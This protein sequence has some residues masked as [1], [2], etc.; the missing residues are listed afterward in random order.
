MR[1]AAR[2]QICSWD[3]QL[4]GSFL[5]NVHNLC[6]TLIR[7]TCFVTRYTC[8]G[9]FYINMGNLRGSF[10]SEVRR[11]DG[12]HPFPI[13]SLPLPIALLSDVATSRTRGV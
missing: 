13:L 10:Q 1:G 2:W 7:A 6:V 8:V 9:M 11:L 4:L 3:E 12:A 5:P